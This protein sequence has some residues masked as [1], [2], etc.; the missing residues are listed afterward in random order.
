MTLLKGY[1]NS[2]V[3]VGGWVPYFLLQKFQKDI[4]FK[5]V[6]SVDI[7]LVIDP[8]LIKS[9]VYETIVG[10]IVR[11]GYAQ[12]KDKHGNPLEFSFER[13]QWIHR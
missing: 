2:I 9:G 4:E 12:R 11:N 10:I 1:K 5:H 13:Y 6:G 3:L 7:D 8:D